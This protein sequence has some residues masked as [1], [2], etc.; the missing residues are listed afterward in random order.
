M[1]G[2]DPETVAGLFGEFLLDGGPFAAAFERV[3]FAVLDRRG[4]TLAPFAQRFAA[5]GA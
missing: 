4:D 5:S 3:E 1:F 2:N